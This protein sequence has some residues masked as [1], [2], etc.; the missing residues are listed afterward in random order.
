M[1]TKLREGRE[2]GDFPSG[3]EDVVQLGLLGL[4][5]EGRVQVGCIDGL[6]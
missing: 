5:G 3:N 4:D 2:T 1:P 6:P